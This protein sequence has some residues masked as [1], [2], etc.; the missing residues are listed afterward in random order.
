MV[1]FHDIWI[2]TN[3]EETDIWNRKIDELSD[4]NIEASSLCLARFFTENVND[5][6]CSHT[7]LLYY[8]LFGAIR[9]GEYRN[10]KNYTFLKWYEY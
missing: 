1:Y 4:I 7:I 9:C 8:W 2:E 10:K 6:M 5:D 3:D